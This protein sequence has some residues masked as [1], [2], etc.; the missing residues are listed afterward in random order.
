MTNVLVAL[1]DAR[2]RRQVLAALRISGYSVAVARYRS[3][4]LSYL[5]QR[6]IDALIVGVERDGPALVRGVR[7]RTDAPLIVVSDDEGEVVKVE[8][9]DAGA[10]DYLTQPVGVEELLAR[11]RVTLRR[12]ADGARPAP[13]R[14]E[15]FT[16]DVA[17]RRL[18]FNDGREARLTPTEWKLVEVLVE[19]SGHLVR[20]EE[21]FRRV[22]GAAAGKGDVLRVYLTTVRRKL[23]PTPER[24]RY[25]IT[26]PGMGVR[27]EPG[28]APVR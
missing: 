28:S 13:V 12:S 14:T 11:L 16:V 23:E 22:W 27:F 20:R 10:D 1:D 18:V 15:H 17:D 5:R 26:A 6:R 19:N 25:F 2:L 24:P 3:Q 8:A 9:L 7:E 4:M 21:L